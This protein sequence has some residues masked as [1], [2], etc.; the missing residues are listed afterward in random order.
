M[1]ALRR[2]EELDEEANRASIEAGD[3]GKIK[4]I[5]SVPEKSVISVF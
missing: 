4:Y 1:F 5:H 2:E 3:L